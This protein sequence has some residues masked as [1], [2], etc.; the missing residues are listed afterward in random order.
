MNKDDFWVRHLEAIEMAGM[1]TKAY[2][3]REGLRVHDL[4]AAR[5]KLKK[6]GYHAGFQVAAA[7]TGFVRVVAE[8]PAT[9]DP[10]RIDAG[11]VSM[12][13][14]TLSDPAWLGALLRVLQEA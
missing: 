8:S 14:R 4:Y 3:D 10:L 11:I 1:S 9:H 13:F 5:K 6:A 2:A 12:Q 7:S